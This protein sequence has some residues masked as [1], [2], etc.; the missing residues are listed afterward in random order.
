MTKR[1][2]R[3]HTRASMPMLIDVMEGQ[4]HRDLDP[5]IKA[6]L[7]QMSA[8]TIDLDSE[9]R[10]TSP[11]PSVGYGSICTEAQRS[12]PNVQRVG[13][14]RFRE[15]WKQMVGLVHDR[16]NFIVVHSNHRFWA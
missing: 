6:K 11:I 1:T 2:R 10:D 15:K 4:G 12:D 5:S 8:A 3:N 16:R 7:R 14:G 13:R 9:P